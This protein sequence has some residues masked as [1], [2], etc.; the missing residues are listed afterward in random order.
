MSSSSKESLEPCISKTSTIKFTELKVG[1][2]SSCVQLDL[3]QK[4]EPECV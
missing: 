2:G 1:E 3:T 4:D